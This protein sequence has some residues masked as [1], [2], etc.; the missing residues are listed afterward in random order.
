MTTY[1][2][3]AEFLSRDGKTSTVKKEI[4]V[5]DAIRKSY[6]PRLRQNEITAKGKFPFIETD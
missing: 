5:Y 3:W 6:D 1:R 2:T 4:S